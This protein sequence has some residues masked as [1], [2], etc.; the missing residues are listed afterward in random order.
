MR[1]TY[2]FL[3]LGLLLLTICLALLIPLFAGDGEQES[4]NTSFVEGFHAEKPNR[5]LSD[6]AAR[7][8]GREHP[9][10]TRNPGAAAAQ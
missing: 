5:I 2:W 7:R 9:A 10:G 6:C 1:T 3:L 8:C 4:T